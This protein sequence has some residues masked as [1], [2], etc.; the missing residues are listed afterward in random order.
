[1]DQLPQCGKPEGN[2]TTRNHQA[3][4]TNLKALLR[5]KHLQ[6]YG[7]FKRAYQKAARSLDDS[8]A[9]TYPSEPTFRRWLAGR[10]KYLPHAE[11]CAVLEAMLPEW[12]AADLF[13]PHIPPR[14]AG[15]T[16]AVLA[17]TLDDVDAFQSNLLTGSTNLECAVTDAAD[18]SVNFLTWVEAS[19]MGDLTMEQMCTEARNIAQSYLKVPTPSLF[20]RTRRLRNR[21]FQLLSGRQK[22]AHSR[23][24]YHVAGWSLTI[25]AWMSTDLNNPRAAEEHLRTAWMCAENA[26]HDVLRAWVRATQ[27]TA[28][29]WQADFVRA[30]RYA[31]DSLRYAADCSAELFLTSALALDIARYGDREGAREVLTHASRVTDRLADHTDEIGGPFA[32]STDRTGG[33]WS[34]TQLSLGDAGQALSA[35]EDALVIFETTPPTHRNIGSER[36]ARCQQVKAQLMLGE[37]DGAWEAL[38]PILDTATE[39]RVKPLIQRVSEISTLAAN[40]QWGNV[41][42]AGEIKEA[43]SVFKD[44]P[45]PKPLLS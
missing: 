18:E 29:F 36:M 8:L 37:L 35:A 23:E 25:L 38:M 12:R 41:C 20:E 33:F 39:Y 27:H 1:M 19:N 42:V 13:E 17:D 21:A 10:I 3:A 5:E 7:V 16:T 30:S 40:S 31:R 28:A 6:N 15:S 43:I 44:T 32:C 45:S 14:D 2:V 9:N 34:D 22:P 4:P 26:D 11:H 24:L